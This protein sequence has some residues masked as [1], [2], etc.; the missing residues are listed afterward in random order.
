MLKTL[1]NIHSEQNGY[2]VSGVS[3]KNWDELK[4][5]DFIV[6]QKYWRDDMFVMCCM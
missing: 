2:F 3:I 4:E 1:L 5:D 6:F